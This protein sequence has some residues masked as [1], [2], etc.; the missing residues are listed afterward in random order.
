M[1][2]KKTATAKRSGRKVA[3]GRRCGL[4]GKTRNLVKTE[5][6]DQWICDDEGSYVLFSYARNSCSRNHRRYTLCGFHHAEG[7]TGAWQDCSS[8]RNAFE[9]EIYVY[10]GTNDHNF[11]KLQNPPSYQPTKCS[12]CGAVIRLGEDGY[13]VQGR[14]YFCDKCSNERLRKILK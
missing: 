2:E 7:H 9:T 6:C 12:S 10:Y 3:A 8:C 5:C 4:C 11:T 14:R 13:S 1:V